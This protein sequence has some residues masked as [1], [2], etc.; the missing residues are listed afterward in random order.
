MR[1]RPRGRVL[2]LL[3]W[4]L[5]VGGVALLMTFPEG[6]PP[7]RLDPAQ[8]PAAIL[9]L[10]A[11]L[12][13]G[14]THPDGRDWI[15]AALLGW[16]APVAGLVTAARGTATSPTLWITLMLMPPLLAAA[17]AWVGAAIGR[18]RKPQL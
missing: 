3:A 12:V 10:L 2:S 17:A 6:D 16:L 7:H 8:V 14:L 15:D 18:R 11:G 13:F 9:F 4:G 5:L 1:L